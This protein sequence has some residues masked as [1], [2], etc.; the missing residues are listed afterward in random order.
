M[1]YT[2]TQV[3]Q[4]ARTTKRA[5]RFWAEQGLFGEVTRDKRGDRIF[6]PDQ[7]TRARLIEAAT[8]V[9]LSLD[10]IKSSENFQLIFK[11]SQGYHFLHD[12]LA[13]NTGV[14]DL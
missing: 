1:T 9:G 14:Y 3:A 12:V 5:I 8:M 4:S 11:I 6:T 2:S 13:E 10:E 7:L